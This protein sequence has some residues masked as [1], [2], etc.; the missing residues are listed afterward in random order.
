MF[1]QT[2]LQLNILILATPTLAG[3]TLMPL[4]QPGAVRAACVVWQG[5]TAE[6][7]APKP[8]RAE[9]A[10][11]TRAAH[12]HPLVLPRFMTPSIA[13]PMAQ[14]PAFLAAPTAALISLNP[15]PHATRAP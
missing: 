3:W 13:K 15:F 4:T 14:A 11:T 10:Q 2:L 9:S 5:R 8:E 6:V 1:L 12:P 7:V